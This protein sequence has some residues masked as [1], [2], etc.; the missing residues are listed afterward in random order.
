MG[1]LR[2]IR[3][4]RDERHMAWAPVLCERSRSHSDIS[5]LGSI[6]YATSQRGNPPL[7][8]TTES[9]ELHT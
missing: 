2:H 5:D 6:K 8:Q 7:L 4:N 9:C 3:K 1:R